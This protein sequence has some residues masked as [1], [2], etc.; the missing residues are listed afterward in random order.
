VFLALKNTN[1]TIQR[2]RAKAAEFADKY[3]REL[4]DL[5]IAA[6]DAMCKLSSKLE[7]MKPTT[8]AGVIALL[9]N[10]V[11]WIITCSRS[12]KTLTEA[13]GGLPSTRGTL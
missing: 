5:E 6:C 11:S 12:M 7:S 13:G 10:A 3:T 8:L 9:T 2:P 4:G 1:T